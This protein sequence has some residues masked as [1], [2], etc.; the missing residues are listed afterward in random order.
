MK[1]GSQPLSFAENLNGRGERMMLL[2]RQGD[3]R[4]WRKEQGEASVGEEG[5]RDSFLGWS[6]RGKRKLEGEMAY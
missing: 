5:G 2:L 3:G 1:G 6:G 4:V